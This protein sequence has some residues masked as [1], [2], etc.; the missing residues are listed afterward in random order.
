MPAITNR[1]CHGLV[2]CIALYV[3]PA[4]E[5]VGVTLH[6]SNAHVCTTKIPCY[7]HQGLLCWFLQQ[8]SINFYGSMQDYKQSDFVQIYIYETGV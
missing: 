2:S 1:Y 6:K 8:K 7:I 3:A 5:K 4:I